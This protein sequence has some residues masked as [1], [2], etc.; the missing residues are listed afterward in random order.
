M[1]VI[2][3]GRV[4]YG[5]GVRFEYDAKENEINIFRNAFLQIVYAPFFDASFAVLA[6]EKVASI[7]YAKLSVMKQHPAACPFFIAIA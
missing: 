3:I 5:T 4:L 1:A 2:Y 6:D 7:Y